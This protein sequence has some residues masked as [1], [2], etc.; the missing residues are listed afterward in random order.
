M[1]IWG[2]IHARQAAAR[3]LPGPAGTAVAEEA[4][5]AAVHDVVAGVAGAGTEGAAAA[6]VAQ[7][8]G[9][10]MSF[11][12]QTRGQLGGVGGV[13]GQKV[14]RIGMYACVCMFARC[15]GASLRSECQP[16]VRRAR[17]SY[18]YLLHTGVPQARAPWRG[19]RA[20]PALHA[21]TLCA[22]NAAGVF[23]LVLPQKSSSLSQ[24]LGKLSLTTLRLQAGM[25][26]SFSIR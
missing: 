4:G 10:F 23:K 21:A 14:S 26:R 24:C 20:V 17:R 2:G 22:P 7:A 18:C 12:S 15:H 1:G 3:K 9:V 11:K 6:A 5:V 13:G 19:T 25:H 16:G 8:T